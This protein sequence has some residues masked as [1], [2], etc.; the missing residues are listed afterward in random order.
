MI[1]IL[2]SHSEK[3][4]NRLWGMGERSMFLDDD[5]KLRESPSYSDDIEACF[6]IMIHVLMEVAKISKLLYGR[7]NGVRVHSDSATI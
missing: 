4:G 1:F 6:L 5:L 7:N 3:N 2:I